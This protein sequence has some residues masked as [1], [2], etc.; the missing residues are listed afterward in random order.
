VDEVATRSAPFG[1]EALG[2]EEG[3]LAAVLVTLGLGAYLSR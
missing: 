3:L 1:I 2:S